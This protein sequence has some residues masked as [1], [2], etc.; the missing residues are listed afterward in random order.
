MPEHIR[1]RFG[2]LPW[3][4][5]DDSTL[6]T[7]YDRHDRPVSGLLDQRGQLYLFDCIEGHAWDVNVWVYTPVTNAD[8]DKLADAEGREFAG[9][10][11]R[12]VKRG[13]TTAALAVADRLEMALPIKPD[14][15]GKDLYTGIM[16]I[17]LTKIEAAPTTAKELRKLQLTR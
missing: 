11:D 7:A 10:V 13:P 9:L 1:L 4:P 6:S 16:D 15:I 14:A 2:A 12:I 3:Q 17:V 5:G 8:A